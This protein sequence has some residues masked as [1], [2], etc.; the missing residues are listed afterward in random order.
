MRVVI[1]GTT[2]MVG[3]GVLYTCL[4]DADITEVV[5]VSRSSCGIQHPKLLEIL[6]TDFFNLEGLEHQLTQLDACFF[7]L[8]VSSVGMDEKQYSHL[9]YDLTMTMADVLMKASPNLV[10]CYISGAGTD[11][12]EQSRTMWARVKGKTENAIIHKGFR[13]AYA[14][15]PGFIQP[16][17]GIR[18]KTAWYQFFYTILKPIYPL[19]RGLKKWVTDTDT[20]GRAMIRVSK[21][22]YSR[23]Y[24]ESVDI[25]EL[26]KV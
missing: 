21:E 20:L 15:R 18:S 7:C 13:D 24:V 1:T 11:E 16:M 10:F 8:G 14:F 12:T 26:G 4:D 5:S 19:L 22:G 6:H 3:Q 9:T 17:R 23:K 2:G 25:N